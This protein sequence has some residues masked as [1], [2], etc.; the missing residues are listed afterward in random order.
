MAAVS[1]KEGKKAGEAMRKHMLIVKK[2][3]A[4]F[5]KINPWI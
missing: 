4:G 1:K 3:L 5:L 2:D